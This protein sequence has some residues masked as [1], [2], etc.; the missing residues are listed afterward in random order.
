[1]IC[2]YRNSHYSSSV[3]FIHENDIP[4][5]INALIHVGSDVLEV[6]RVDAGTATKLYPVEKPE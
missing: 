5:L 4:V 1:M 2:I 3:Q 6:Y